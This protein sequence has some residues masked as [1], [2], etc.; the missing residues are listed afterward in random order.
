MRSLGEF[1][2]SQQGPGFQPFFSVKEKADDPDLNKVRNYTLIRFERELSKSQI[3]ISQTM[4]EEMMA[5]AQ[6][7]FDSPVQI[8]LS[9]QLSPVMIYLGLCETQRFDPGLYPISGFPRCLVTEDTI[10]GRSEGALIE[11]AS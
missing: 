11:M 2:R 1:L 7:Y 9:S 8:K 5:R 4:I 10:N 3:D 6:F